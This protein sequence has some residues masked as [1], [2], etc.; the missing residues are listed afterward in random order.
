V[1][2]IN[3]ADAHNR[4]QLEEADNK[5]QPKQ[6]PDSSLSS[7]KSTDKKVVSFDDG[8][9]TNPYNWSFVSKTFP[10]INFFMA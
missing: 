2:G 10:H 7:V 6:E 3:Y 4:Y 5:A 8:D 9:P 1:S